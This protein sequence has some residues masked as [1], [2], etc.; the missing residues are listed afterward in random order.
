MTERPGA[1]IAGKVAL[2]TEGA[3]GLGARILA[4]AGAQ[5]FVLDQH[6]P[7]PGER[8]DE[9]VDFL[10][11]DVTD[12]DAVERAVES[13]RREAG[14]VDI[15][16]AIAGVLAR[17]ATLRVS[18]DATVDRLFDINIGGVLN[19]VRAG[20]PALIESRG[21][22]V[23]ISLV[24]AFVNG[25]GALPYAMSKAAVEQLGRGLRVELAA[26]GVSV[27]TAYFAVINTE[28][29]RMASTRTRLHRR[30]SAPNRGSCASGSTPTRRPTPS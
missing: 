17:G 9:G 11:G 4:A 28:M 5:V 14:R 30:S 29:T 23:L 10:T 15:V 6:P 1:S 3:R 20:L 18:S 21:R 27:T 2:V 8:F 19:T 12:R 25:A 26:H 22:L 24:F 16:I 7:A 13:I